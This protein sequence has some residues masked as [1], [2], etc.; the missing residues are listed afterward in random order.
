MKKFD[1][2][3]SGTLTTD[4]VGQ[5]VNLFKQLLTDKRYTSVIAK[6]SSGYLPD[7]KT[8]Q[9]LVNVDT[10]GDRFAGFNLNDSQATW[11]FYV[12]D[13]NPTYISF[14]ETKVTVTQKSAFGGQII[15][16]AFAVEEEA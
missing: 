10:M 15:H 1:L 9:R 8:C 12:N 13:R 4:N 14:S 16:W 7:V 11:S 2:N 3:W 6:E 5:V